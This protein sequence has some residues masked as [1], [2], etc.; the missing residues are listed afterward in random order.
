MSV[1]KDIPEEDMKWMYFEDKEGKKH[2]CESNALDAIRT[3]NLIF[4]VDIKAKLGDEE[5]EIIALALN[6]NDLFWWAC[7][8]FEFFS[9]ED[10]ESIYNMCFDENGKFQRWGCSRWICLR[11]GMRPQH[12]I[13]DDMKKEGCWTDDLEALPVRENTG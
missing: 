7:A 6:A 5:K 10:I 1:L 4:D 9:W 11:R 2:L 8:D 12:P 13:E 3:A